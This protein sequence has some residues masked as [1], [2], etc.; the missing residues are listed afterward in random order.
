M[1]PRTVT[2]SLLFGSPHRLARS[3][4]FSAVLSLQWIDDL[5]VSRENTGIPQNHHLGT[6][7]S[8]ITPG[9]DSETWNIF[10][11]TEREAEFRENCANLLLLLQ[12]LRGTSY[13]VR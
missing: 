6:V 13:G 5:D 3:C 8:R 10:D 9:L 2:G 12:S 11:S 4:L 7:V 1:C